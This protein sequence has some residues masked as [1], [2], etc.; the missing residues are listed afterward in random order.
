[1]DNFLKEFKKLPMPHVNGLIALG[2][3]GLAALAIYAVIA[4]NLG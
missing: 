1:M 3:L 2:A 4:S